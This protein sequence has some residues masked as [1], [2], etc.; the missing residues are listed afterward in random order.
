MKAI[1]Y[2]R[3]GAGLELADRPEPPLERGTMRV[4]C[5]ASSVNPVDWKIASGSQRFFMPVGRPAIPGFD[6][7]GEILELGP[8]VAE[9][10]VGQRI[11]ARIAANPGGAC[12]ERARVEASSAVALPEG[13]AI[14]DAAALPLA[15]MT[16]LQALRD[17]CKMR[18]EGETRRILVV[19]ASGGVGH[20]AV[21]LAARAGAHV[22]GVCSAANAAL[23]R[24][25]G[26]AEVIDHR[27]DPDFRGG[28]P[29]DLVLD[30]AGKASIAQLAAVLA[31]KGRIA[32]VAPQPEHIPR[33]AL[34]MLGIGPCVRPVMLRVQQSDLAFL[35]ELLRTGAIRSVVGARFP[36]RDLAIAWEANQRGGTAGKIVIDVAGGF[37]PDP[38][39][40]ELSA[41]SAP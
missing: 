32:M 8:G 3:Y 2:P 6:V 10:S 36:V 12:A 24:G 41:P 16:A 9:F 33:L 20:Y 11:V 28:A 26:A 23:V 14:A 34:G 15:G 19:G 30:C 17:V 38:A 37:E 31:S 1:I 40:V 7:V 4:R 39:G 21:Q 27:V 35:V 22:T 5:L 13:V 29:Y 25:L 18:L